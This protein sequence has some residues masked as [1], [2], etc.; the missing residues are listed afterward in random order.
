MFTW[1]VELCGFDPDLPIS[2]FVSSPSSSPSS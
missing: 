2:K 1:V